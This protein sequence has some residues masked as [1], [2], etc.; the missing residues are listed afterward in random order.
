MVQQQGAEKP[1]F[2]TRHGLLLLCVAAL[3]NMKCIVIG[4]RRGRTFQAGKAAGGKASKGGA[5]DWGV[6]GPAGGRVL[7]EKRVGDGKV[8]YHWTLSSWSWLAHSYDS[9]VNPDWSKT[10]PYGGG[11]VILIRDR[12]LLI[13][14]SLP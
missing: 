11:H 12:W 14:V 8:R 9:V 10:I 5:P 2:P 6:Q 13:K 3:G 4:G 1:A 7:L